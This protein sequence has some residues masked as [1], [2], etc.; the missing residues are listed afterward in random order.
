MLDE[1][2]TRANLDYPALIDALRQMFITGCEAPLRH[3]HTIGVPGAPDATL[4]LMPA[5]KVS[6]YVGVKMV[7]VFPGNADLGLPAIAGVYLLSH[8]TT[9]NLLA[10]ID[11]GELT[12]RRTAAASALASSYLS[13]PNS[14]RLLVCG[15]GRLSLNLAQAHSAVRPIENV[16]IWGRNFAK[17]Q[18][19]AAEAQA[20]GLNAEATNDLGTAVSE[21]DIIS[22]ATLSREPLISG[23]WLRPGTHIDLVG[24]FTP[25]MRETDNDAVRRADIYVDTRTGALKEGGDLVQ[26]LNDGVIS[27]DD[28]KAELAELVSGT[29]AGRENDES[30]TLFKS[31]GAALED[32]AGAILAFE[33]ESGKSHS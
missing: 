3:H 28:I 10:L 13:R 25:E 26:P 30:I 29:R 5:W 4:L 16:V 11:G 1:A 24:A 32:L 33:M 19:I 31:V 7:T 8:G 23:E 27:T 6:Q 21:A 20:L 15:T 9:G 18:K 22:C 2:T 14:S 17:A 12:A